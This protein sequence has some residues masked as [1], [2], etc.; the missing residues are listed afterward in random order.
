MN[1][2]RNK[3]P[4]RRPK[5][6]QLVWYNP[7]VSLRGRVQVGET[8][9]NEQ[10]GGEQTIYTRAQRKITKITA[11]AFNPP[12]VLQ[13][14]EFVLLPAGF[15]GCS[16]FVPL[17]VELVGRSEFVLLPVGLVGR[18]EF[19]LSV[20]SPEKF[21]LLVGVPVGIVGSG[22]FVLLVG[23]VGLVGSL[24]PDGPGGFLVIDIFPVVD[25]WGGDKEGVGVGVERSD[26]GVTGEGS[27]GVG[28]TRFSNSLGWPD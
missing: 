19:V 5:A 9:Q 25:G 6:N 11:Q 14:V 22:E 8:K 7:P 1:T 27:E 15:V 24:V 17:P 13:L 10:S 28:S 26:E 18:R 2:I 21:V 4:L 12:F 23:I 20:V 3:G 16:E